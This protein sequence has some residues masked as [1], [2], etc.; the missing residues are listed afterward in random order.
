MI[1]KEKVNRFILEL[2][3]LNREK[4]L[5]AKK[6]EIFSGSKKRQELLDELNSMS[7]D[8]LLDLCALT[9]YGRALTKSSPSCCYVDIRKGFGQNKEKEEHLPEYLL[10]NAA[11]ACYLRK[12]LAV[13][14]NT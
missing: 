13:Y 7:R 5:A 6:D 8:E 11:F 12:A 3:E 9:A 4:E 1:S 14:S 10:K 2:D